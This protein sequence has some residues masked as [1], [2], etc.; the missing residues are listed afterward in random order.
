MT[1]LKRII[2][3][4]LSALCVSSWSMP[5]YA[6]ENDIKEIFQSAVYGG[7][8]GVVVGASV[9]A[10]AH[11]P[12]DHLDY[13]GYGGAV[14]VLAGTAFGI[15]KTSR[16]LA[17]VENGKVKLG[18]PTIMPG[19]DGSAGRGMVFTAALVRGKF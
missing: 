19:L 12:A 10:F 3:L 18:M 15:F 6:A 5:C 16:A 1:N 8:T 2:T 17:E 14:G 9:L 4:V 7:L 11:K 13:M